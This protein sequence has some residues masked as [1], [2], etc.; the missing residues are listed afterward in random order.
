VRDR[1][2]AVLIEPIRAALADA[3][4]GAPPLLDAGDAP[5]QVG[6]SMYGDAGR[7][8]ID[9]SNT[10]IDLATDALPPTPELGLRVALPPELVGQPLRAR[11]L[12][13]DGP[14]TAEV[15]AIPD[16]RAEVR[17]PPVEVYA[18]VLIERAP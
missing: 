8:L 17:L 15:E 4:H 11:V 6:L 12:S 16:G 1:E 9:V 18:S 13:P 2:R 14:V 5:W 3:A 7:L 10:G